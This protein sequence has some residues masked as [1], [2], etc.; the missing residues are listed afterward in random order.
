MKSIAPLCIIL[1]VAL[2]TAPTAPAL[3]TTG[4]KH[5]ELVEVNEVV[6]KHGLMTFVGTIR[7]THTIQSI[8]YVNAHVL[9]KQE[10][11]IIAIYQGWIDNETLVLAPG[12]TGSFFVE[13][14][15]AEGEYDEL[16]V[17][18]HG[19][20]M[21]PED[22]FIVGS[23]HIV[24]ESVNITISPA[25]DHVLYGEL[26]NGTNA[27]IGK[28]DLQFNLFDARG[29]LVGIATAIDLGYLG[30]WPGD[31]LDFT[32]LVILS[33]NKKIA[34]WEVEVEINA[35][36]IVEPDIPTATIGAT[37]GQIKHGVGREE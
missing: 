12:E 24:E 35:I 9:L 8:A 28:I 21:S 4:Y 37:W 32:A 11:R 31:K 26:I 34:N 6:D 7:N 33:S 13:S 1:L 25:G 18:P 30:L 15:Y 5:L 36:R 14:D 20:M 29:Q 10:G 19:L 2:I 27:L 16:S 3:A 22:D 23:V 17:I